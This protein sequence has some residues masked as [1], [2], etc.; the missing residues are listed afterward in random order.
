MMSGDHV[1]LVPSSLRAL[2]A[3]LHF[4]P[5]PF[6]PKKSCIPGESATS[7]VAKLFSINRT[8]TLAVLTGQLASSQNAGLN[9]VHQG[10]VRKLAGQGGFRANR[11]YW[12]S[13][14]PPENAKA[15]HGVA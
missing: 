12:L 4:R 14:C 1:A 7:L 11:Q 8:R 5:R 9:I 3:A 6:L 2:L 15:A 10:A 13:N